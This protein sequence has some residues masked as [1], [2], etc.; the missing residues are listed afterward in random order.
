MKHSFL[1]LVVVRN[2]L[3]PNIVGQAKEYLLNLLFS[4]SSVLYRLLQD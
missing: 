3:E 4:T 1:Y 2:V